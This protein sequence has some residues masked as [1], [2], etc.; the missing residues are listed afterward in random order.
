MKRY[1]IFY[2]PVY[3]HKKIVS[4]LEIRINERRW[5]SNEWRW[6]NR[7]FASVRAAI[8]YARLNKIFCFGIYENGVNR[9][10]PDCLYH[11]GYVE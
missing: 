1:G 7:D 3:K 10:Y 6:C 4:L 2:K 8:R 5:G 11:R 9:L